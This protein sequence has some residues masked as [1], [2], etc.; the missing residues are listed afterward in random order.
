MEG[1]RHKILRVRLVHL[2]SRFLLLFS[3]FSLLL[4]R[5]SLLLLVLLPLPSLASSFM[6]KPKI[7]AS[8]KPV[9]LMVEAIAGDDFDVQ[10]LMPANRN[11]HAMAMTIAERQALQ[12]ADLVVWIGP[13]MERFLVKP[14]LGGEDKYL[15][16]ATLPDVTWPNEESQDPHLWLS[17]DNIRLG[18]RTIALRLQVLNPL[19]KAAVTQRLQAAEA[20][21]LGAEKAIAQQLSHVQSTPFGVS[22]DGYGHFVKAFALRQAGAISQLPEQQ[23]AVRQMMALRSELEGAA[24]LVLEADS[25]T[26]HKQA[27]MLGLPAVAVDIL[28]RGDNVNSPEELLQVVADGFET[29]L[30]P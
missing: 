26:E 28:G 5:L 10:V 19:A 25:P 20:R 15:A 18:Y 29:C 3:R 6:G 8:I 12:D 14:L 13:T 1:S 24:C 4:S 22:H 16:L 7:V 9:G 2:F 17:P 23:M 11:P 27:A 30:S 21:L